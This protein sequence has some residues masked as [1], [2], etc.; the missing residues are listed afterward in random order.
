VSAI[1][2]VR[3]LA[4]SAALLFVG[5]LTATA[6]GAAYPDA[7]LADNPIAYWRL[8]EVG[9]SPPDLATNSGSLGPAGNGVYLGAPLRQQPGALAGSADAAV[10]FD[11]VVQKLDVPHQAALNPSGRL[12]V[13]LWVRLEGG[14]GTLR[15]PLSS[16]HLPA[17]EA[18]GYV[19]S[20][21]LGNQW[22]FRTHTGLTANRVLG[23]VVQSNAWT[24]LVGIYDGIATRLYV[25]GAA[26]GYPVTNAYAPN[27]VTP[28]RIGG[29]ANEGSGAFFW[30]GRIDEV[31]IYNTA[32]SPARV[33]AHHQAGTN[34]APA[35]P[36]EQV[37]LADGPVG[38]WRLNEPAA[39][40][41]A[42]ATNRGSLGALAQGAYQA[43]ASP[44]DAGPRPPQFVGFE[45]DN[46]A[47][48]FDGTNGF[49]STTAGLM[50][51]RSA[52]TLTGWL[53]R[54]GPQGLRAGLFGQNDAVELGYANDATLLGVDFGAATNVTATNAFPDGQWHHVAFVRNASRLAL[55]TNATLA[56]V[57]DLFTTGLV[58]NGSRFH[59]GGAVL[60]AAAGF[61][62]GSLDEVAVFD[63]ALTL[64][65]LAGHYYS[66]VAGPPRVVVNPP[67]T[68]NLYAGD[69]LLLSVA[70]VG[71]AP[72]Q[73]QWQWNSAALPGQTNEVLS[74]PG[75]SAAGAGS[76]RCRV[77]NSHGAATSGVCVVSVLPAIPPSIVSP[78]Q[79]VTTYAG[80]TAAFTVTATGPQLGYQWQADRVPLP[81]A[82]NRSLVMSNV[83]PARA[84]EYRVIVAN[85]LGAA[86]STVATLTVLV[87]A[88][89]SFPAA[90]VAQRPL[91][92][93]RLNET[94]GANAFD[95]AGHHDAGKVGPVAFGAAG[96]A[97]PGAGGFEADN[98]AAGFNGLDAY[99]D[100]SN[101]LL[102]ARSSFTLLGWLNRAREQ[103][104][105]TGLWGQQDVVAFGFID[106][107]TLDVWSPRGGQ[108]DAPWPFPPGEWHFAVVVGNGADLRLYLDGALAGVG[109][110]TTSDYGSSAHGFHL[111]G[112][113]LFDPLDNNFDG[114]LDEVAV[115]DR[116]LT[117]GEICG[118]WR[119]AAQ[120]PLRLQVARGPATPPALMLLWP[121]GTLQQ[122]DALGSD[123][124]PTH[125]RDVPD[126]VS[127]H[128][129][130]ADQ[131]TK[132][133]RVR[134]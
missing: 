48:A 98:R 15:S 85:T 38:Y 39:S 68:T 103:P 9:G 72:L 24:H 22:E 50:N 126:A 71:S 11:G 84:G 53:K 56:A 114:L 87:P 10:A 115:F 29:G 61:F 108:V 14:L 47:C 18:Y 123:G 107:T 51:R 125:W 62:R 120:A 28:L 44:G 35:A 64:E 109:G 92:Y 122:A 96:P 66:A 79:P 83:Q 90:V 63:R 45:A 23:G 124:A 12:T 30:P 99:L 75:I 19:F 6:P 110:M 52:F 112:G 101:S 131:A 59:L 111:G 132:F 73:L 121:C 13:E 1:L 20:T 27:T 43:G 58:S 106:E 91:A 117:A 130:V 116:A 93:W 8:D 129:V 36:Y 26:V 60:D 70:A 113:S 119:A 41:L 54:S 94:S 7:V 3:I 82:T 77:S 74:V 80:L 100:A 95:Y 16:R 17:G 31:A 5:G 40:P 49:V 118:L 134:E 102:N 133:F 86:T 97:P 32:L 128:A 76:Y 78:P 127:P 4:S 65:Q 88:P 37:V 105:T 55:Y 104:D 21:T 33:A 42:V 25:N 34:A 46:R 2:G 81:G 67:A 89:G 57:A 69:T